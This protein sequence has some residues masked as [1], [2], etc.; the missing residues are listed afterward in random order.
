MA[1]LERSPRL[2][3]VVCQSITRPAAALHGWLLEHTPRGLEIL[4]SLLE[5]S[6]GWHMLTQQLQLSGRTKM[7]T[8]TSDPRKSLTGPLEMVLPTPDAVMAHVAEAW[9]ACAVAEP[10]HHWVSTLGVGD[11]GWI[12]IHG[13]WRR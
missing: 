8:S 1:K 5:L 2:W 10:W 9:G 6:G 4:L 11:C 13:I 12:L 3:Q 7:L